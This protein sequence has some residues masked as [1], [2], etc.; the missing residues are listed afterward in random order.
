[1]RWSVVRLIAAKE[2]RDLL[3]DRRTVILILVLPAILYPVFGAGGMVMVKTL[4]GQK[5]VLA[6]VGAEHLPGAGFRH[7]S[8]FEAQIVGAVNFAID[9]DLIF[10]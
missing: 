7:R 10:R 5:Q 2:L 6:V 4:L 3:R 1:M 8:W 9:H